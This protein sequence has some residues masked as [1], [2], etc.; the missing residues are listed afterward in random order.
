MMVYYRLKEKTEQYIRYEYFPEKHM[1]SEPGI[2]VIDTDAETI[3][4][5]IMA[6][7]DSLI[8]H[9]MEEQNEL[10]NSVNAMRKEDGQPEL[11]EEEWPTATSEMKYATYGSHA[12][13]DII[14][15]YDENDV[16]NEGTVM[17]Y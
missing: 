15:K 4:I 7:D 13:H 8:K 9:S 3:D 14:K 12:I 16:P 11:T 1:E 17:W 6:A 10:R 5:E 2:I